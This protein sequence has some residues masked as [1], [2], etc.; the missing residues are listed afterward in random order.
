MDPL[1]ARLKVEVS[2]SIMS[3]SYLIIG[4]EPTPETS[5]LLTL[6]CNILYTVHIEWT[7][8]GELRG[9]CFPSFR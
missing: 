4:V 6:M 2:H 9:L 3:T 8:Q 7:L 5:F 1:N